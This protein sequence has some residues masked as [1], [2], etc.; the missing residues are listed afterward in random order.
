MSQQWRACDDALVDAVE[1]A[2]VGD[3]R[4]ALEAGAN[5]R[6]EWD[7]WGGRSRTPVWHLSSF[8]P[9]A[10]N[11]AQLEDRVLA[12]LRVLHERGGFDEAEATELLV[13]AVAQGCGPAMAQ[14]LLD[15]GADVTYTSE[16]GNKALFVARRPDTA[17]LLLAAG[18]DVNPGCSLQFA[19]FRSLQPVEHARLLLEAGADVNAAYNGTPLCCGLLYAKPEHVVAIVTLLLDEG[20]D[21]L[22]PAGD[23]ASH[24][25]L[26]HHAFAQRSSDNHVSDYKRP[27]LAAQRA[28]A[29]AVVRAAAWR[30]RRHM[31]LA[32]R[33]RY[34]GDAAALVA[35]A[36]ATAADVA[37]GGGVGADAAAAAAGAGTSAAL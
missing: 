26:L 29:P 1:R 23:H 25:A 33:G 17:T 10:I 24:A 9:R 8:I 27:R 30:R 12:C 22:L 7:D 4:A 14:F 18:A 3:L 32:V 36:A 20:A 37:A 31:L 2:S 34:G 13:E 19:V 15:M 6:L 5:T 11:E 21:P 35:E 16:Y 28:V